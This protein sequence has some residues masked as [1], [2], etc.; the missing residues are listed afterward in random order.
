MSK[1]STERKKFILIDGHAVIYRAYHAF[2]DLSMKD[3]TMINAV[4][5]F[6]RILLTVI[7]D[8]EP[9]Y[10]LATFDTPKPT[11]RHAE[12][13][14]YKEHR[15]EMPDDLR[16]QIELI[17]DVVKS[18]NIPQYEL[19]GYEADD[20]IGTLAHKIVEQDKNDEVLVVIVTGDRDAFQ[21]V[22][23]DKVHVWMPGRGKFSVDTEYD[24][25]AVEKKMGVRPDQI[26]DLK[27]LM[28]DA[29]DNIPG[30]KGIGEKTAVKLIQEF[31]SLDKIYATIQKE[32]L[33]LENSTH[34]TLKGSVLRKLAEGQQDAVM[35]K[36]LAQIDCNVPVTLQ[37]DEC[38]LSGYRKEDVEKLFEKFE[39]NSLL[40]LLPPDEFEVGVQSALF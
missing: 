21:L 20:L 8:L 13:L 5:G 28:G 11:F 40:K 9:E 24:E 4:Y 18:F 33:S 12:Y 15:A 35:S 7:R 6:T 27:A 39:F 32:N 3:G 38:K 23:D 37:I 19:P 14:G 31:G 16:P 30:I 36:Q 2:P 1:I 22:N 29:S 25:K 34:P 26:V 17:K 10:I